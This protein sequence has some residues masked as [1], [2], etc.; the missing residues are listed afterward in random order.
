MTG[1]CALA[2]EAATEQF[3]LAACRD[4]GS[5]I[6]QA[7]PAR[8]E[9][10]RVYQHAERVLAEVGARFDDLDFVAFG[11]GPGSFTGVRIAAAAVQAIA[12]A[13]RIPV[14][15]VSSLAVLA[16]G[17]GRALGAQMVATCLDARMGRAYLALY[18]VGPDG[19]V[20][21]VGS[22]ALVDP[23][24]FILPGEE[25]FAAVGDGWLAYPGLL[26][27]HGSRAAVVD[28][29]LL[30]SP[31]DLLEMACQDFRAG[32]TVSAGEALPE[33]LGQGPGMSVPEPRTL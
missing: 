23:R 20:A 1:P 8:D 32:R 31:R 11:C 17:A 15:R 13:R 12:F 7:R 29:N 27:R 4:G 26:A 24:D 6:W 16:A 33:Y 19:F 25:G 9:T 22:D 10:Q 14:C 2:I 18:R 28:G 3:G 21:P 5:A 30:P